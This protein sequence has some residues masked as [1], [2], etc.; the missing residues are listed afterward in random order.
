M[1]TPISAWE[2]SDSV[3]DKAH[4]YLDEGRVTQDPEVRSMFWAVSTEPGRRYRVIATEGSRPGTVAM[5]TCSCPH[6]KNISGYTVA[7]CSHAVAA[8]LLIRAAYA[9]GQLDGMSR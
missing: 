8:L 4:R 3:I 9:A 5:V 6:G 2:F 1:S 7:R